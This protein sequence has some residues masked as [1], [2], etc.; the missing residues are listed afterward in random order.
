MS[1]FGHS[2]VGVVFCERFW[3]V[4]LSGRQSE[5]FTF[6]YPHEKER[7]KLHRVADF[8]KNL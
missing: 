4:K 8:E 7:K 1:F 6:F 5:I 3:R 2:G